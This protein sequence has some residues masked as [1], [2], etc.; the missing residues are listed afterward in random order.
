M[1]ERDRINL[2]PRP[3]FYALDQLAGLLQCE[4]KYLK[5]NLIFYSDREPG[6]TPKSKMK[7]INIAQEGMTPEWRVSERE[8]L[9]FLRRRGVKFY[10]RGYV[11]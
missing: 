6:I 2:P 11:S 1:S 8:F 9:G 5:D 10:E 4:L 7:A 3:F